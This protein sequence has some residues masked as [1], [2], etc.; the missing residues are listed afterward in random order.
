MISTDF[1]TGVE[2]SPGR[3]CRQRKAGES[4]TACRYRQT[5]RGTAGKCSSA[6]SRTRRPAHGRCALALTGRPVDRYDSSFSRAERFPGRESHEAHVS[7][8]HPPPQPDPRFPCP[9][10]VKERPSR[11]EASARQ[12]AQAADGF[13]ARLGAK[14]QAARSDVRRII[15]LC[16]CGSVPV[17]GCVLVPSSRSFRN[18]DAAWR[19]RT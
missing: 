13:F 1:S 4:T 15:S 19:R 14:G 8:Q 2:N 9:H 18:R 16:P 10:G 3:R 12:G 17:S 11:P 7:A 5:I 6:G